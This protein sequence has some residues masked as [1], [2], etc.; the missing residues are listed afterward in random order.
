MIVWK[1]KIL[2]LEGI[3]PAYCKIASTLLPCSEIQHFQKTCFSAM[4]YNELLTLISVK[5]LTV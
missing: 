5:R 2:L 4:I 1:N 3:F